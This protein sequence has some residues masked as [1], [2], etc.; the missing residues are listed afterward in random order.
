MLPVSSV[1]LLLTYIDICFAVRDKFII[2]TFTCSWISFLQ[3]SI[4][5]YLIFLERLTYTPLLVFSF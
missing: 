1:G 4:I 5:S 3:Y 2:I